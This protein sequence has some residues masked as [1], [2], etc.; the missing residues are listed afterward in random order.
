MFTHVNVCVVQGEHFGTTE[1]TEAFFAMT[2][3]FQ[4]NDVSYGLFY[5]REMYD[6]GC[7]MMEICIMWNKPLFYFYKTTYALVF[8][9][10]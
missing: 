5:K 8:S 4:S 3:L 1:A 6:R 7:L 10:L 2:R 9:K